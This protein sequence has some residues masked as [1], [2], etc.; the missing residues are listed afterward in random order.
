M[1]GFHTSGGK[2]KLCLRTS[3]RQGILLPELYSKC[4]SRISKLCEDDYGTLVAILPVSNPNIPYKALQFVRWLGG[5][6]MTC[7]G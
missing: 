1:D 4:S 5:A 6:K 7:S 2:L 3:G